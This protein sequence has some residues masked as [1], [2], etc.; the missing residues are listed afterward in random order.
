[1]S[2][3]LIDSPEPQS[4]QSVAK[5]TKNADWPRTKNNKSQLHHFLKFVDFKSSQAYQLALRRLIS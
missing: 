1:M 3:Q 5:K 2:Q 4:F